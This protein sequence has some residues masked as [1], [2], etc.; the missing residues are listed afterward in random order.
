[1]KALRYA[2]SIA[3]ILAWVVFMFA[4]VRS[5]KMLRDTQH[6]PVPY[7]HSRLGDF[8]IINMKGPVCLENS[9]ARRWNDN[10]RLLTTAGA[11]GAALF[12]ALF[13]A[14]W[15]RRKADSQCPLSTHS[16]H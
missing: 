6:A 10:Q 14:Q 5:N 11:V 9:A 16:C 15:R 3:L 13:A 7:C 12:I 8:Q 4:G 1:M 2:A